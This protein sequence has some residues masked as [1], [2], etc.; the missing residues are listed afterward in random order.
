MVGADTIVRVADPNYYDSESA[1]HTAFETLAKNECEFAVFGRASENGF[2]TLDE[3]DL[4]NSL[5]NICTGF[6]EA[7]FRNDISST[8]IRE[9]SD[10]DNG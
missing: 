9:Q 3:L 7:E 5:R 4:P 8:E 2:R 1:M 6:T 10:V